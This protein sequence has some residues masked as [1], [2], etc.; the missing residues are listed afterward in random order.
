MAR[1][2]KLDDLPPVLT[3]QPVI[4]FTVNTSKILEALYAHLPD[5]GSEIVLF[6]VKRAAAVRRAL[7]PTGAER[8]CAGPIL[9]LTRPPKCRTFCFIFETPC[10]SRRIKAGAGPAGVR[11]A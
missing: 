10:G 4:D 7:T 2:G 11:G 8:P 1:S 9:P 6:D 5:N 3:F